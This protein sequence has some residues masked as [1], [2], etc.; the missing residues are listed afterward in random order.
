MQIN[1]TRLREKLTFIPEKISKAEKF[2]DKMSK[3][4]WRL[5]GKEFITFF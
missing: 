2:I 5:K 1:E 4:R 3:E